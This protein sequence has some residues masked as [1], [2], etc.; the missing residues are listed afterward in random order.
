[1][2]KYCPLIHSERR[3]VNGVEK[4]TFKELEEIEDFILYHEYKMKFRKF[5][6]SSGARF[7]KVTYFYHSWSGT[8]KSIAQ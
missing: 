5:N 6:Y 8:N 2:D 3:D 4:I 1:M 7:I